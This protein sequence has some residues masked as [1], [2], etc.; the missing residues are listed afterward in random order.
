[1]DSDNTAPANKWKLI[2]CLRDQNQQPTPFDDISRCV[3]S[4][5]GIVKKFQLI[6]CWDILH[7]CR[8]LN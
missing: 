4:C 7:V 2:C 6:A 8:L 1:M 3:L 5:N